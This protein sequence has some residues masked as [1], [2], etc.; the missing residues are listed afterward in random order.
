MEKL[1]LLRCYRMKTIGLQVHNY[2]IPKN[3]VKPEKE[4]V[5]YLIKLLATPRELNSKDNEEQKD[6]I[7]S[8]CNKFKEYFNKQNN[9]Y[10]TYRKLFYSLGGLEHLISSIKKYTMQLLNYVSLANN[11]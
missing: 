8:S 1:S 5:Q 7:E 9:S 2:M 11:T 3:S 10:T 4:L 6:G